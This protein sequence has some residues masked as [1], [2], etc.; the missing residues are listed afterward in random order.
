[1]AERWDELFELAGLALTEVDDGSAILFCVRRD[2]PPSVAFRYCVGQHPEFEKERA[3]I[4]NMGGNGIRQEYLDSL[5]AHEILHLYG[6]EDLAEGK[7]HESLKEIAQKLT[8][9]VMHTLT[10]KPI[11]EYDISEVTAYLVGWL[12]MN[13][14]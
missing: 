10:Q 11:N 1:L 5:I 14:L 4:Y 3:I 9:D 7:V 8:D 2:E 13:P 12:E 6:A